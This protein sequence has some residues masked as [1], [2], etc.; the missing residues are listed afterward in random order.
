MRFAAI[1]LIAFA[2][3]ASAGLIG[4]IIGGVGSTVGGIINIIVDPTL[5]ATSDQLTS[6]RCP[7]D[8]YGDTGVHINQDATTYQ[9]A[10]QRGACTWTKVRIPVF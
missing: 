6:C 10:Y 7:A 8:R 1:T 4:G 2:S 5:G 3:S 9:C